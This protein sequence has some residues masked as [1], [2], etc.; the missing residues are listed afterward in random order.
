[1]LTH[2]RLMLL[3]A[4]VPLVAFAIGI[5]QTLHP[6]VPDWAL[7]TENQPI[8]AP[9]T[10]PFYLE[11]DTPLQVGQQGGRVQL[12]VNLAFAARLGQTALLD[13]S[14]RLKQREQRV[15]AAL[16]DDLLAAT[17]T[18]QDVSRLRQVLPAIFRDTV[19]QILGTEAL[20]APVDEVLVLGI[21]SS[22]G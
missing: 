2:P 6:A 13:L 12:S 10:A 15:L 19:N 22:G 18:D 17:T 9:V 16:S 20:P 14:D 5:S 11:L 21:A 4:T 8:A 1:M 7:P 3:S